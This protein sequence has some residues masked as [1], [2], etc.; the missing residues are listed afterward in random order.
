[1]DIG[2][3]WDENKYQEVQRR[4]HVQVYEVVSAFDDPSGYEIADPAGHEDR[5]MW[6]GI[7][8]GGRVLAI[9]FSEEDL[10][11]YRLITAF[12]AERRLR[13]EYYRRRNGI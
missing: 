6:I 1:M 5:R 9:V 2:F 10:P 4:H 12:D 13:D 8:T 7:T 11:I 3:I